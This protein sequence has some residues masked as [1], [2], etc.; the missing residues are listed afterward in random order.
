M[1]SILRHLMLTLWVVTACSCGRRQAATTPAGE[2]TERKPVIYTVSYPLQYFA[3]R[4][5][6]DEVDVVFPAPP[7]AP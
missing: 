1:K 2:Q 3:Q 7:D 4:I 6:G 5:G